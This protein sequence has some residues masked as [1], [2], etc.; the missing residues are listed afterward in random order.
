MS[1]MERIEPGQ[2]AELAAEIRRHRTSDGPL[3]LAVV[4]SVSPGQRAAVPHAAAAA[5]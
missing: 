1:F 3:G 4:S 2:V 5:T